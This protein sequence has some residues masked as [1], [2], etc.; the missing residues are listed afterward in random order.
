[1]MNIE[2]ATFDVPRP[3]GHPGGLVQYSACLPVGSKPTARS[4]FL[5]TLGFDLEMVR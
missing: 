3:T 4:F 5:H 2:V 1:M